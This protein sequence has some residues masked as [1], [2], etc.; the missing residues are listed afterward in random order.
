MG[1]GIGAEESPLQERQQAIRGRL[2]RASFSMRSAGWQQRRQSPCGSMPPQSQSC[3]M[4]GPA[5]RQHCAGSTIKQGHVCAGA[6]SPLGWPHQAAQLLPHGRMVPLARLLGLSQPRAYWVICVQLHRLPHICILQQHL[7]NWVHPC[8]QIPG[9]QWNRG[10]TVEPPNSCR[11]ALGCSQRVAAL[12]AECLCQAPEQLP[13]SVASA[14][15]GRRCW[16]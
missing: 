1:S 15:G 16:R 13:G 5:G 10:S 2:K 6:V 9:W 8:Q 7:V 14:H 3:A 11:Q 4:C 12:A